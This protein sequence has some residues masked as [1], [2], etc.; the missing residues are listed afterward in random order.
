MIPTRTGRRA[1]PRWL[2][3]V[4]IS[5]V[6]TG[7]GVAGLATHR[8]DGVQ[9][10]WEDQLQPGVGASADREIV[11][12]G[13]DRTTLAA[14]GTGWP[15]DRAVHAAL[16]D[17]IGDASPAVI[18][19]DVLLAAERPGDDALARAL[20][21]HPTV[22]ASALTLRRVEG[23][24]RADDAV[25]PTAE[26]AAAATA[27]GH[28]NVSL[29]ADSGV[30]RSLPVLAVDARGVPIPSLAL[31]AVA[32]ADGASVV[33]VTR[34]DGVQVGDRLVPA[35]DGELAINWSDGLATEDVVPA[36]DVLEGS[37]E[38][39]RFE[40]AI[41][42]VGVTEPTLGDQHLVPVDRSGATA[43]VLVMANA[44]NTMVTSG[45]LEEVAMLPQAALL[46]A[47]GA[48]VAT[49]FGRW[50]ISVAVALALAT[51]AVVVA[52]ATWRFHTAGELWNVVWPGVT[53]L[54]VGVGLSAWRY[55]AEIRH[56]RR[57]W[58]LFATYV[59]A[60]VVGELADP[61]RLRQ[62]EAGTRSV[63]SVLF[64]DLRGFTPIAAE[65]D[66]SDVRRLLDHYYEY[67]VTI[68]HGHGGTVMQF[69]GDEVFAIFGAPVDTAAAAG[70]AL[71]C[72]EE[73]QGRVDELDATLRHDGLPPIRFGI[74][75]HRGW[76]TTAHVGTSERRQYSAIGDAVNVGSRL[77]GAAGSGEIV[78]SAAA[79]EEGALIAVAGLEPGGSVTLKGVAE[80]VRIFRRACPS[81]RHVTPD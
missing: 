44:V 21:D 9:T 28:A 55:V 72:A 34:G 65:L 16:I 43:G 46:V 50:R 25:R 6:C 40:D 75:V 68:V 56:R 42:L 20:A 69:V 30:V 64:C 13:F 59:P 4:A 11:V 27:I 2:S 36:I 47:I 78:A 80:P 15:V 66:P 52:F 23:P 57:A 48:A 58:S 62:V 32:L 71:A 24:P 61:G 45:Y 79:T 41:V 37:V 54:L 76:V 17:A 63:V 8:L 26:L 49:M 74:G 39:Q 22:I 19:Y 5:A 10:R 29:A 3:V 38:P 33:P 1:M 70:A 18:V 35:D 53:V 81:L 67:A 73:L 14:L 77:C 7:V 51:I 31:A 60:S 12:V